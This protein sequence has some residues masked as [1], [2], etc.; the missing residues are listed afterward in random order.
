MVALDELRH[1]SLAAERCHVTQSALSQMISKLEHNLDL[2]LIDR[3]RRRVSLTPEGE[4]FVESARRVLLELEEISQDLR[5]H[6]SMRKGRVAITALPSLASHW[7]PP[8]IVRFK[9]SY[10]TISVSLNDASPDRA[11]EQV[12]QRQADF[13]LTARGPGMVGFQHR[14]LFEEPFVLVCH[15]SHILAKR[16]R[17]GLGDLAGHD[18]I[19]LVRTGSIAQHLEKFFRDFPVND[20]GLEVEQVSTVAGLVMSNLGISLV[21]IAAIPYFDSKTVVSIPIGGADLAR[22]IYLVWRSAGVLS[23]AAQGFV[24][25]LTVP[26]SIKRSP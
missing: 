4:R 25:M 23:P 15:K 20:T 19:R 13:A 18:Y 2:R 26:S 7:L 1:F 6:A 9:A 16:K 8:I 12:R 22:P 24:D 3:D 14:L 21:P 17:L 5:D 11:L 10:P